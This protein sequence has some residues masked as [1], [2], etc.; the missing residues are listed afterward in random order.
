MTIFELGALGEF[1]SSIAVLVTLIYLAVQVRTMHRMMQAN[2]HQARAEYNRESMLIS[3]NSPEL[4]ELA[5]RYNG[6]D[7]NLN[8]VETRRLE[9]YNAISWRNFENLHYQ[10]QLGIL[11]ED[12]WEAAKNGITRVIA[13]PL[14]KLGFDYI[15]FGLRPTFIQFV[16]SLMLELDDST[17][18]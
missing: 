15:K 14:G 10:H 8:E 5:M 6:G 12:T 9:I 2:S 18:S 13:L 7:Q 16:E 11:S 1:I 4:I 17:E 3:V